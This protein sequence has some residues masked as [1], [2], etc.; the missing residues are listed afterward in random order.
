MLLTDPLQKDGHVRGIVLPV[1]CYSDQSNPTNF[2]GDKNVYPVDIT[3]ENIHLYICS[4]HSKIAAVL[5]RLLPV[6]IK[7]AGTSTAPHDVRQTFQI[8]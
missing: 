5:S 2:T 8:N 1:V 6:K 7:M 4:R 3:Y